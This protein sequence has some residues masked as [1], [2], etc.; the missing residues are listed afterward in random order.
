MVSR[1]VMPL[2]ATFAASRFAVIR[3]SSG[4]LLKSAFALS[5]WSTAMISR[6]ASITVVITGY[7]VVAIVYM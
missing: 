4:V 5:A 1:S 6:P 2:A 3:F 7:S